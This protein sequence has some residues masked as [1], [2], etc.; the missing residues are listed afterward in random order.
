MRRTPHTCQHQIQKWT[1]AIVFTV[2]F[3]AIQFTTLAKPVAASENFDT[4]LETTYQVQDTGNT[5]I[6][7][8]FSI[9][10]KK[11]T[12]ALSKYGLKFGSSNITNVSITED[13]KKLPSEVVTTNNQTSIGISFPDKV[14]GE[15]KTRTFQISFDNPDSAIVSG[16][17]LEVVVP[18][19]QNDEQGFENV[20]VSIYTPIRFGTPTRV[21]PTTYTSDVENNQ[22]VT[23]FDSV[24]NHSIVAL[25]GDTQLFD[26]TL[27]YNLENPHS[28]PRLTQ[29]AI[30][31]DTTFQRMVYR[32]FD[33]SPEKIEVDS[34][35]NWIATYFLPAN[36]LTVATVNAQAKVTLEP[37]FSVP[38]PAVTKDLTRERQYWEISDPVVVDAT[39]NVQDARSAYEYVVETLSY[40]YDR[41][42]VPIIRLGGASA[43]ATPDQALCQEFTDSF[44]AISRAKDIPSRRV[45][46]YAHTQNETLRPLSFVEDVLHAWPEY[47][48]EQKKYW[49]P[50]DP[51][52]ENT[53]GGINYFDQFDLNHIVFAINGSDSQAPYSAGSY[54]TA[55]QETKDVDV[56]FANESAVTPLALDF[57]RQPSKL[58]SGSIDLPFFQMVTI[59][60]LSGQA[61]YQIPLTVTANNPS[62]QLEPSATITVERLLPFQTQELPL[63]IQSKSWLL[64]QKV[65]LTITYAENQKTIAITV[66]PKV[67]YYLNQPLFLV[68]LGSAFLVTSITTRSLLVYFRKK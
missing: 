18:K 27:R 21:T 32:S 56:S 57:G 58:F 41:L 7:H 46:G 62:I 45:T 8:A 4:R 38:I 25:F 12:V 67:W 35:G 43:L 16:Q 36:T 24:Q 29:V 17:V 5:R 60:N 48:D 55:D 50:I 42:E 52:W 33:P 59:K 13:G 51:T 53:S 40:N 61:Q 47:Y 39:K 20:S 19:L 14:V 44:I 30:P 63:D 66:A 26:M 10:N 9:T 22:V 49:V 3:L 65:D 11:P 68:G 28:S 15:E 54:K 31:P 1:Q 64:P 34:D 6:T 23:R 37:D 2:G